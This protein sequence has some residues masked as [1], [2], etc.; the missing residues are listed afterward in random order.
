MLAIRFVF[1]IEMTLTIV[2]SKYKAKS[3]RQ[4]V[5]EMFVELQFLKNGTN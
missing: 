3:A 5:S 1:I 4:H 2:Y